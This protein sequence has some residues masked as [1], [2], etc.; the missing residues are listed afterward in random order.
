MER[1][2]SRN[3]QLISSLRESIVDKPPYISGTLQLPNSF[4]SLNIRHAGDSIWKLEWIAR[5]EVY[6][7]EVSVRD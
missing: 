5:G 6:C 3:Q 4:M 7:G 1:G 2:H